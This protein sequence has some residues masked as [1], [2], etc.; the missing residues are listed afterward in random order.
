MA[1]N[2]EERMVFG[3]SP[4]GQGDGVPLVLLGVPTG[5][6]DYM[7]DGKTHLF[8]LT[9]AGIPVKLVLF[10]AASHAEAMQVLQQ[11]AAEKGASVLDARNQDFSIAPIEGD[12]T[13]VHNQLA[14]QLVGAIVKSTVGNGGEATAALLLTESVLVGVALTLIRLG[15]DEK[16]LDVMFQAAKQRLAEIRLRDAT[17]AGTG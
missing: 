4:E 3:V 2:V 16:V 15:G 11:G 12:T 8:D 7:K 13:T 14:G 5:A 1:G 9:R 17:P 10:G 6:W